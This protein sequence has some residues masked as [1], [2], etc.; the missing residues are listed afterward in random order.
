MP[1]LAGTPNC[2][3]EGGG[4]LNCNGPQLMSSY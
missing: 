1:P 3:L 2:H 4:D